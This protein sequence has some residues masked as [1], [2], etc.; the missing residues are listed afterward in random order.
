[1]TCSE[2]WHWYYTLNCMLPR[3]Q[4]QSLYDLKTI[5][6]AAVRTIIKDGLKEWPLYSNTNSTVCSKV[7]ERDTIR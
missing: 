3:I 1:M 5:I 4:L 2:S 6:V 7:L